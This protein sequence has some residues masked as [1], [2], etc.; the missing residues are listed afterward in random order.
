LDTDPEQPL[1][2][3]RELRARLERHPRSGWRDDPTPG[4][5][6]WLEI[7]DGFRRESEG[8]VSLLDEHRGGRVAARELAVVS[9]PRLRGMIARLR[10]HH[11]IE[12]YEY[13]PAFRSLEPKLVPGFDLL[14]SDHVRL[15]NHIDDALGTLAEF[16]AAVESGDAA[17][18]PLWAAGR[19]VARTGD[20]C[21][22]LTRHLHDEEELIIPLLIER[23]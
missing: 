2:W 5:R 13:F 17:G 23:R 11:E 12:D 1:A 22:A 3:S 21:R 14:A 16:L 15:Q 8:L 7:H 18:K 9:G 4:V 19:Y 10:G 6:F 20:L